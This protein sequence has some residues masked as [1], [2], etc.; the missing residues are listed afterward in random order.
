MR[1]NFKVVGFGALVLPFVYSQELVAREDTTIMDKYDL[2]DCGTVDGSSN[3]GTLVAIDSRLTVTK[4]AIACAQ[5]EFFTTSAISCFCGSVAPIAPPTGDASC[6][7]SCPGG[8]VRPCG[9]AEVL[10]TYQKKTNLY[11]A[12]PLEQS[13]IYKGCVTTSGSSVVSYIAQTALTRG[14]CQNICEGYRFYGM[15]GELCVCADTW[16]GFEASGASCG[17]P[18][19]GLVSQTCGGTNYY[20]LY[21]TQTACQASVLDQSLKNPSFELGTAYW[22]I[23]TQGNGRMTWTAR[24]D[25][26]PPVG[27]K[28]ARIDFQLT[29][30]SSQFRMSQAIATCPGLYYRWQQFDKQTV[31]SDCI[32]T[33]QTNSGAVG[34]DSGHSSW[35]LTTYYFTADSA[36]TLM[37]IVVECEGSKTVKNLFLDNISVAQA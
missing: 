19:P 6:A 30:E 5:Y 25:A 20:S 32:V 13:A 22:S 16:Q 34:S 27:N 3:L 28:V 8:G 14:R 18:C 17:T 23:K 35:G 24:S 11:I 4:C 10:V 2:L 7:I 21:T 33:I 12:S 9:G 36:F 15:S 29:D 26:A 37:T 31:D 1:C